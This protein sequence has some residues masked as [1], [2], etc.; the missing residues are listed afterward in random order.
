MNIN[1]M[2][3]HNFSVQYPKHEIP[4]K[5]GYRELLS[6]YQNLESETKGY[7]AEVVKDNWNIIDVGANIGMFTLLFGKLTSGTVWAIEASQE[8]YAML[9]QNVDAVFPDNKQLVTINAYIS[10]KS[11]RATGEIHYLWTGRG[12]VLRNT[13]EFDFVTL[14][15][16]IGDSAHVDL[17]KIDIDGYDFEA[18]QG[19]VQIIKKCKPIVVIELVAEA[20]N[21][22]GHTTQQ[23]ADFMLSLNYRQTRV[24]DNCN[25]VFEYHE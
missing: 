16:L 17:I 8:N 4:F 7:Y 5:I 14:D 2:F 11:E 10:N 21:L 25:Y 6:F 9:Q 1:I 20:L 3:V 19:A 12:S 22:H 24:L 13:G 18:V 15:D 23:V